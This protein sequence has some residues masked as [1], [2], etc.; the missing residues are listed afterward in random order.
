MFAWR[1]SSG[2]TKGWHCPGFAPTY[3]EQRAALARYGE[4]DPAQ[5][6][7]QVRVVAALVSGT[8]DGIDQAAWRRECIYHF[9]EP[10]KRSLA[11]LAAH[12]LHEGEQH[13]QDFDRVILQ[14]ADVSPSPWRDPSAD[15]IP[16]GSDPV[17][18]RPV[19][20]GR[21]L[22][23]LVTVVNDVENAIG[24]ATG[25]P[26]WG[27]RWVKG[28]AHSVGVI[29]QWSSDEHVGRD[30]DLLWEQLAYGS[31]CRPSYAQPVA[32]AH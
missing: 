23:D 3:Q 30:G 13:L 15:A 9:P 19:P 2:Q 29:E 16:S 14:V 28:R 5:V 21:D 11:W 27:H 18:I 24:A 8:V 6:A 31:G 12:T 26:G 17:G 32:F 20:D 22:H 10:A 7:E 4:S 1:A 25:G